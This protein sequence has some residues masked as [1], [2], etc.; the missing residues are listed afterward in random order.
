MIVPRNSAYQTVN[1]LG[2]EN[3]LHII[4]NGNVVERPFSQMVKRCDE[5]LQKIGVLIDALK[6]RQVEFEEYD[7]TE[8]LFV[9]KMYE[10][11]QQESKNLGLD[12]SKL[13]DAY[14][15]KLIEEYN[16]YN[17]LNSRIDKMNQSKKNI[18][19]KIACIE[20][21]RQFFG[22]TSAKRESQDYYLNNAVDASQLKG[23][24]FMVGVVE[25]S[26]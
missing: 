6:K 12:E 2:Q 8:S 18:L 22:E 21:I 24:S 26:C 10:I 11:W 9:E 14:E 13:I 15:E 5:S 20:T 16:R 3:L 1:L 17:D 4:D 7:D 23:V 19:E 25:K